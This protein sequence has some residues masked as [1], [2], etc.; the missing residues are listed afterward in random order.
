MH[1]CIIFCQPN[2]SAW[3]FPKSFKTNGNMAFCYVIN[4][5]RMNKVDSWGEYTN[6]W[7]KRNWGNINSEGKKK[8]VTQHQ[9]WESVMVS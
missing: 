8:N 4:T 6:T 1:Q 3:K 7:L 5:Q 2:L 9:V